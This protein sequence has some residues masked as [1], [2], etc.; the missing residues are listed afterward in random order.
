MPWPRRFRV[1]LRRDPPT[2]LAFSSL[3][4][5]ADGNHIDGSIGDFVLDIESGSTKPDQPRSECYGSGSLVGGD[6]SRPLRIP[7]M[8]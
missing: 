1:L 4:A 8:K 3:S 2:G 7:R 6:L 5:D